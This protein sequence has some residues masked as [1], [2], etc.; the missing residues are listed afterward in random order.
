MSKN[1]TLSVPEEF[2]ED[3]RENYEGS[4]DLERLENWAEQFESDSVLT[5]DRVRE[6][7]R[8]VIEEE[9]RSY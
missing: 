3:L 8:N 2:A 1:T 5:E 9:K 6:I 7:C 4:N